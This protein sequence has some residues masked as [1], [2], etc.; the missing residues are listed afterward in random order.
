MLLI[1]KKAFL[2]DAFLRSHLA[3]SAK[4]FGG[5]RPGLDTVL[6]SVRLAPF[7]DGALASLKLWRSAGRTA[8]KYKNFRHN[9]MEET[10]FKIDGFHCE[11]CVKV[12]TL[13]MK[14]IRD[15][16][17]VVITPDGVATVSANRG[18]SLD[19]VS[20]ALDGL[21]YTVASM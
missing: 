19:E 1:N 10:I 9:I 3:P 13:K 15:V 17:D 18:I 14:K 2:F 7:L 5:V 4:A 11:A 12:S 8:F 6:L 20:R 21:G 16:A